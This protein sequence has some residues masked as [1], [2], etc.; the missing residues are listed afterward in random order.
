MLSVQD[1]QV[2]HVSI[3]CIIRLVIWSLNMSLY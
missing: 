2:C 3:C 1:S